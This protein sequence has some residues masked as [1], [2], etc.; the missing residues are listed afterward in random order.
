MENEIKEKRK[1][2]SFTLDVATYEEFKEYCND[3]G[4][5]QSR[6]VEKMIR[7]ELQKNK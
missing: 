3:N 1:P 5:K 2:R 7:Q 4:L 6:L